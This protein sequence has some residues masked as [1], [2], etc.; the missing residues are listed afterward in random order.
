MRASGKEDTVGYYAIS[1]PVGSSSMD[2]YVKLNDNNQYLSLSSDT[3]SVEVSQVLGGGFNSDIVDSVDELYVVCTGTGIAPCYSYL[4]SNKDRLKGKTIKVF[5]GTKTD[6]FGSDI[7]ASL[8]SVGAVVE[9]TYSGAKQPYVQD[10]FAGSI[11]TPSSA[12]VMVV[13]QKEMFESV[14]SHC[15]DVGVGEGR[16]FSNF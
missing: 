1:T 9:R 15:E 3:V 2:F 16:V 6:S 11:L 10:V 7:A 5:W 4:M 12:G 14:K 8:E 13:G